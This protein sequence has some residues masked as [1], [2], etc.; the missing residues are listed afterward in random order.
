MANPQNWVEGPLPGRIDA[1]VFDALKT[2][3]EVWHD[4]AHL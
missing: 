3:C 2:D 1:A 4:G